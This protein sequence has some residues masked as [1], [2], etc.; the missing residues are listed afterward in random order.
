MHGGAR[1]DALWKGGRV[2]H[3][4]DDGF[5]DDGGAIY[6]QPKAGGAA[7]LLVPAVGGAVVKVLVDATHVYYAASGAGQ[8]TVAD[9]SH[10]YFGGSPP[11]GNGGG[12]GYSNVFVFAVP[13][14]GSAISMVASGKNQIQTVDGDVTW[15]FFS[16]DGKLLRAREQ[17]AQKTG[18][19]AQQQEHAHSHRREAGGVVREGRRQGHR[20][21]Q[22]LEA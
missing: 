10:V 4:R 12:P 22:R 21:D 11:V 3:G 15:T 18:N 16:S 7:S 14:A 5:L 6:A 1:G 2:R 19:G 13:R 9:V 17:D 20:R 8:S